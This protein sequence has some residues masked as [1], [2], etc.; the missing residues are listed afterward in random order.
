[1]AYDKMGNYYDE[2][3][4]TDDERRLLQTTGSL[5][6][7]PSTPVAPT[8]Y[9]QYIAKNES[10][11]KPDIGYH[12]PG[13]STAYGTYGIT[14]GAYKDVQ[15]ANPAFA[16][17]DI[18]SLTPEEQTQAMDT[19]TQQ[20]S[21]YL[22]NYGVEPTQGNLALAH[23]LGAKGAADYLRDGTISKAAAAANGGEDK[24]RQI[25]DQRLS[26]G[27]APVSGAAQPAAPVAPNAPVE[28]APVR[29]IGRAH[30]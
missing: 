18:T 11:N 6:P 17:R 30:V 20:N 2:E 14:S 12:M 28:G 27:N 19:Y 8:E 7:L 13:K 1:M 16:G 10:G 5:N 4:L 21:K 22:Q 9:N 26:L 3:T 29:Q 25:A 24:V 15:A 23:F